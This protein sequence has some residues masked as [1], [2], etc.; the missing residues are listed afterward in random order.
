MKLG[1][2]IIQLTRV[3]TDVGR[4][5]ECVL[6]ESSQIKIPFEEVVLY[7]YFPKSLFTIIMFHDCKSSEELGHNDYLLTNIRSI[8]L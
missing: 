4:H 7:T 6:K 5:I 8:N 1:K 2:N 3:F